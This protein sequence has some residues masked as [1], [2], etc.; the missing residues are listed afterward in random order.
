MSSRPGWLH[1]LLTTDKAVQTEVEVKD[2]GTQTVKWDYVRVRLT[3]WQDKATQ[4]VEQEATV[5]SRC[6]EQL[7][8]LPA[9]KAWST[10]ARS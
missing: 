5:R 9:Y 1:R 2:Q 6:L 8:E 7:V 3:S 4:C 10:R